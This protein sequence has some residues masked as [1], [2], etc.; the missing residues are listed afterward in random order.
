MFKAEINCPINK[1]VLLTPKVTRVTFS[2][3]GAHYQSYLFGGGS[4]AH[5][6]ECSQI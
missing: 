2:F 1:V 3:D 6:P 5:L 4:A